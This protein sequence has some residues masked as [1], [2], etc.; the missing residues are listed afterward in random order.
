MLVYQKRTGTPI[1]RM[2]AKNDNGFVSEIMLN[3]MSV[4]SEFSFRKDFFTKFLKT[5]SCALLSSPLRTLAN[6]TS[7]KTQA[8]EIQATEIQDTV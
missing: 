5:P 7:R 4:N 1:R 2:S 3:W 8:T 6:L